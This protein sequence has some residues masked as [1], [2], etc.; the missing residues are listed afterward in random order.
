MVE[1][2]ELQVQRVY[3]IIIITIKGGVDPGV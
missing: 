2:L 3:S 1:K